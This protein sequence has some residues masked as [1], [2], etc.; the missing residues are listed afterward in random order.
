MMH[1]PFGAPIDIDMA[2]FDLFTAR[3]VLALPRRL[4]EKVQAYRKR[5]RTAQLAAEVVRKRLGA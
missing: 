4:R 5:C 2:Q 1:E 3:E